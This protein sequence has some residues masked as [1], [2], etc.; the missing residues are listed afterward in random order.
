MFHLKYGLDGS[1]DV[2]IRD[3]FINPLNDL[4]AP[5]IMLFAKRHALLRQ[6][7]ALLSF[8]LLILN[9]CD[10]AGFFKLQQNL[11]DVLV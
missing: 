9:H 6:D 3:S 2:F 5:L 4:F 11:L 8:I 7:N 10:K 1:K